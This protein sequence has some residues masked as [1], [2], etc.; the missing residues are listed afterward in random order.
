MV[1][2]AASSVNSSSAANG[3]TS[4][5][6]S[7]IVNRD[8]FL[9]LLVAQL[10][11][12]DPLN[13]MEN[14]EFVSELA[15]FSELEQSTNQTSLLEQLVASQTGD[16]TTQALS[17]IGKEAAVQSDYIYHSP[18][19]EL[20][21]I[22][23][24]PGA[25]TYT[26]EAITETGRVV[27]TDLVSVDGAGQHDYTFDGT[28]TSGD[29]LA[30]GVYQIQIGASTGTDGTTTALPSYLRGEIEGVNFVDGT[31]VL[32]INGQPVEMGNVYA[33]FSPEPSNG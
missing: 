19:N 18:G 29:Q 3:L 2:E 5:I 15:V 21:F 13:P 27:F 32:M 28:N 11:H 7:D 31:P 22:F 16:A 17:M 24:T 4:S 23:E 1:I 9:S 25:G 12:Q 30:G 10:Q 6:G 8:D 14:Q 20:E 26:V 33:V